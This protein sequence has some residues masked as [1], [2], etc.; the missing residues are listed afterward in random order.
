MKTC[1]ND[2]T[3]LAFLPHFGIHRL[4]G[5]EY[6]GV[7]WYLSE[8]LWIFNYFTD[9][10]HMKGVWVAK[11]KLHKTDLNYA[12]LKLLWKKWRGKLLKTGRAF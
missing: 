7:F 3:P 4:D 12:G 6:A 5:L 10:T 11:L 1:Q 2:L 9:Y 8:C